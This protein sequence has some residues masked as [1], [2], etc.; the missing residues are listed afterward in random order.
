[1]SEQANKI[2]GYTCKGCGQTFY[3]INDVDGTT[4]FMLRC[5]VA[6]IGCG[7][8]AQSNF[9]RVP[10]LAKPSW[11]WFKPEGEAFEKLTDE[12]KDH[13]NRGGLL[14]RKLDAVR[15]EQRYGF[16]LRQG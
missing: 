16:N 7:G 8:M 1:M 2:N 12:E 4:P 9:Y 6:N 11:E 15:L 13:V 5:R 14:L 3:T 10:L